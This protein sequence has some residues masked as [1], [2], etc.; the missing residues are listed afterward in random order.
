MAN[1]Q[2]LKS[3]TSAQSRDEA[4][5]NGRKGGAASGPARRRK[6]AA[7]KILAEVM[8]YRPVLSKEKLADLA[9][10]GAD[11]ENGDFSVEFLSMIALAQKAMKGDLKAIEMYL[12]I[13]GED[14]KWQIEKERLKVQKE[15]VEV[16]RH[17][18]GFMEAMG[19][20]AGEVFAGGG[21]T[22]EDLDG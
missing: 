19:A 2:N 6:N 13:I 5:K 8:A 11:A 12:S 21:D 20:V 7:R 15:A 4:V 18:D 1:P 3:F 22:P 14:P 16:I 9:D 10:L 17:S